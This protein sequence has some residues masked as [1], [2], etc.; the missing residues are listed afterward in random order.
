ML[1]TE[2]SSKLRH[3]VH[4]V[5]QLHPQLEPSCQRTCR[6]LALQHRLHI[7]NINS[8]LFRG[9]HHV[10]SV[11]FIIRNKSQKNIN[12]Y[13]NTQKSTNNYCVVP[14]TYSSYGD[15]TFAAAGPRLWNSLLVQLRNP[16]I[17]YRLFRQ[18]LKKHL[19][20]NHGHGAL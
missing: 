2:R 19:F 6:P 20:G 16:V 15:T 17:T 7:D 10:T 11:H 4:D 14:Q 1:V 12:S 9:Q 5:T 13:I 8:F 18:Q 3:G